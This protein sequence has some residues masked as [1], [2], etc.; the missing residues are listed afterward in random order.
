MTTKLEEFR[1]HIVSLEQDQEFQAEADQI[2]AKALLKDI[3]EHIPPYQWSYIP[4]R[5]IRNIGIATLELEDIA[6]NT[7]DEIDE[8]SKA[9]RDF[10]LLWE[11]LAKLEES[12]TRETALLNA[13]VNYELAGY[14]ANAMCIAKGL[15]RNNSSIELP[16]MMKMSAIFLQR[17]FL[18]LRELAK[19]VQVEPPNN[20]RLSASL[21]E[22]MAL[23]L[24]GNA[25]SLALQFF[26]MGDMSFLEK[27]I[28]VFKNSG[29]LFASL[30]LVE[31]YNLVG[32]I[33]SLLPVMKRRTTWT[34]LSHFGPNQP[35]WQRYLKLLAR[36][37]GTNVY[38]A[39][40][41][42]ELWPS[43]I[44]ALEHGLLSSTANKIIKMPTS[45]GKT[46]IAELAIVHTL[47]SNPGAKCIY[48]APYRALVSELEQ[49]FLHLLS[50]LGYRVSSVIGTY[51][52][53]AFEELLFNETDVIVTTPEKLDLLLR[54]HA[55]FLSNVR[56]IVLDEVHIIQDKERG[57]KFELLLTRL[58]RKLS[59][60][61]FLLLSAVVPQET[62]EEFARWF[63]ASSQ[64]DVMTS[65]WRPS[66]Q[67]YAMF[68]S[69][70]EDVLASIWHSS[71]QQYSLFESAVETGVLRYA[72][73]QDLAVLKATMPPIIFRQ[74]K[75]TYT[76][77]HTKRKNRKTFPDMTSKAQIAAELAY[78]F[79][80][81]GPVL[82][83]CAAPR[84]VRAV[85]N[86][87]QERLELLSLTHQAIPAHFSV[88]KETRSALLARE[89]LGDRP[90]TSWLESKIGV[91]YGELPDAIRNA[92]E[93]DF[94]QRNMPV[95][96]ATNTLAQGVNLPVKTVIIH[97]CNRYDESDDAVER[98]PARDYWNIAGRAG[99]AGEETEGLII[100]VKVNEQ[101]ENDYQYY[102]SRKDRVEPISSVLYQ[103]LVELIENR[104]SEGAL[105]NF[106]TELDAEILAL[107]VE[108]DTHALPEDSIRDLLTESFMYI[109]AEHNNRLAQIGKLQAICTGVATSVVER[110]NDP[111]LRMLYSSTGLSS[112]SCPKIREHILKYEAKVR[113]LFLQEG[114]E[115][116]HEILQLLLPICLDLSEMKQKRA[117]TFSGSYI[118]LLMRWVEGTYLPDLLSEFSN[119]VG[120]SEELGKLIDRLFTYHLPWS[121]SSYIRIAKK[122]LDIHDKDL[123]DTT[124]F[125]PSIVKFG[126]P[127]PIACWAMSCGIPFRRTAIEI[128]SAFRAEV[129]SPD[130]SNFLRWLNALTG[131]RLYHD[132]GLTGTLLEDT[133]R[134]VFISSINPL[135]KQFTN[136]E[137]FLPRE[138]N[139]RGITYENRSLVALR[140]Q[141][142]Q[143]VELV[144]DYDNDI[145]RNAI[146]VCLS[147]QMLGY[148]PRDVAQV[149]AVEMDAGIH[150]EAKI[151]AVERG[152]FPKV[153]VLISQV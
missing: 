5:V 25:F 30:G 54:I 16:P 32:S 50:D 95:L 9:A 144:R 33:R 116:V 46:R 80:G 55:E 91:H 67:R 7:P 37:I 90:I 87:L 45:A 86:A 26:L 70:Q 92:V 75:Y 60:S 68:D 76:N 15:M 73:E 85:A 82:V 134:A 35:R 62:L 22:A 145:D 152:R 21:L 149:L 137:T 106:K 43:Q 79:A 112:V 114:L 78:R 104:L 71:A 69:Y 63:R 51:E 153:S 56:L 34:L 103:K 124:K 120:S 24:A 66:V 150:L 53:D 119:Q 52:S 40:S 94:R 1:E 29:E 113:H 41:I 58:K 100:H 99:R 139:V 111:E 18:Q 12:T 17:R 108:E 19:K 130:Y 11:A 49:S 13:A 42:S 84:F 23:A 65:P 44:T 2:R 83:F 74:Q 64:E 57:L 141:P 47:V 77:L 89:W 132:L 28:E 147:S 61:R 128:A 117:S 140:A 98:I 96:I 131:E 121:I 125:L 72:P 135:M 38:T 39:R 102:L 115:P 105:E 138:I 136:L 27:S 107:L 109:Q 36:G 10:A 126:V 127:D 101:D 143:R 81:L 8:L 59:S 110:V 146:M 148:V 97:S 4:R 151:V 88:D 129:A 31:E 14:Q 6:R 93:I 142:G 20:G 48:V 123:P 3:T 133:S 122:V 118:D